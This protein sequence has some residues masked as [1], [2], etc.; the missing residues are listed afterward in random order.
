MRLGYNEL[1]GGRWGVGG[2][3]AA[4]VPGEAQRAAH[5]W[6]AKEQVTVS[7]LDLGPEG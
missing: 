3:G 6:K 7:F 1:L 2:E 5:R 4:G